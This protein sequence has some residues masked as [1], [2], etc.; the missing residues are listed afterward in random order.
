[1]DRVELPPAVTEVG[2][3]DADAP[4]GT[5]VTLRLTDSA[6]PLR[7]AVLIVTGAL[8]PWANDTLV[9]FALIEKLLPTAPPH[10]GNLKEPIRVLQLNVP[11]AGMYSVANQNVQSSAGSTDIDE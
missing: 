4:A 10:P 2:L 11:F 5:P 6:E 7:T 3:K 9:G 8:P 1:M